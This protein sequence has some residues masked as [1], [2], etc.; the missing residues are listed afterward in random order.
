MASALEP[1]VYGLL[2]DRAGLAPTFVALAAVTA[3]IVPLTLVA[4][5]GRRLSPGARTIGVAQ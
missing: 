1:I 2:A 3:L 5:R 4:G